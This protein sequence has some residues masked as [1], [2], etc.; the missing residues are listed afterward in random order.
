[1]DRVLFTCDQ[2]NFSDCLALARDCQAGVEIQT[3]SHPQVLDGNWREL[4]A[5]YRQALNGFAAEV[6]CHGAFYDLASGSP[7]RQV[8]DVARR[9]YRH[10]L[11]IADALSARTVVFHANYLPQ[12]HSPAYRQAW[13][14]YNLDFWGEL[15]HQAE[16]LDVTIALENMW[17][18][19]PMLIGDLIDGIGSS[20]LRA[21]VD[22]GHVHLYSRLPFA[23]WLRQLDAR[24]VYVHMNNNPGDADEHR[25]LGEGVI[26][27]HA[28]L[29]ALRALRPPP[30]LSL[31]I[32]NVAAIR[33]SLPFLE[34]A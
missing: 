11:E 22:V 28:I 3:F 31:E 13:G 19:E 23:D 4:I 9:R 6:A 30:A 12:V 32:D 18:P 8:Q 34:L 17:E 15:A 33:K 20:H 7:D 16:T 10:N 29:P 1:M 25:A 27:Y 14:R 21:C 24:T 26:D 2:H 5:G